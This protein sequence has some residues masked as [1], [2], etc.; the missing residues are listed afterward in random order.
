ML[1]HLHSIT[2]KVK[3]LL[4]L[5][6]SSA[7]VF[8]LV[9]RTHE[10]KVRRFGSLNRTSWPTDASA[11]I[12]LNFAPVSC[13]VEIEKFKQILAEKQF[14]IELG[15]SIVFLEEVL[16]DHAKKKIRSNVTMVSLRVAS[17]FE[18]AFQ[19]HKQIFELR[20]SILHPLYF[21]QLLQSVFLVD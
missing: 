6:C 16:K 3:Y 10:P 17:D 4:Y 21:Q 14:S 12:D 15:Q 7:N 1:D 13:R 11:N 9:L 5:E 2:E 18:H 20:Q 19:N 8:V